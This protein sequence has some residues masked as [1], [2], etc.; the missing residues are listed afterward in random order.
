MIYIRIKN[1]RKCFI[2]E[3]LFACQGINAVLISL[4]SSPTFPRK[5]REFLADDLTLGGLNGYSLG[6]FLLQRN[7]KLPRRREWR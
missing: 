2:T 3:V 5:M 1:Y 6:V 7:R 4:K